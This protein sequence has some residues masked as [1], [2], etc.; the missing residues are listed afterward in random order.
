MLNCCLRHKLILWLIALKYVVRFIVAAY[1]EACRNCVTNFRAQ[2]VQCGVACV[3]VYVSC[4]R[5]RCRFMDLQQRCAIV[6]CVHVYICVCMC[7]YSHPYI[8][9]RMLELYLL[10]NNWLISLIVFKFLLTLS[11]LLSHIC[12][13]GVF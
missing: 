10:L 8:F 7:V 4:T 9:V 13:L 5:A 2:T 12:C 1:L 6:L 11:S 3:C